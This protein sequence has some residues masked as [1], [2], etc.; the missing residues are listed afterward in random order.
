[1]VNNVKFKREM[2]R[3]HKDTDFKVNPAGVTELGEFI[4]THGGSV[5]QFIEYHI[6]Y[7]NNKKEVFMTGGVHNSS[8]KIIRKV[9]DK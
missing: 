6:H 8:S 7:T 5:Q 1:M 2:M 4:Y 3:V 9:G